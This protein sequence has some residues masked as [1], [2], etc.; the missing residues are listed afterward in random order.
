MVTQP[1]ESNLLPNLGLRYNLNNPL[2]SLNDFN[3][4][5][6]MINHI[7]TLLEIP[8]CN[9]WLISAICDSVFSDSDIAELDQAG[10]AGYWARPVLC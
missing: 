8:L 4:R 5:L 3:L 10:L 7:K 1:S 2:Y 6:K 9:F